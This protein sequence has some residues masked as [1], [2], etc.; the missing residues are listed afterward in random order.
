MTKAIKRRLVGLVIS[1]IIF[2]I[3]LIYFRLRLYEKNPDATSEVLLI[4]IIV[5][6]LGVTCVYSGFDLLLFLWKT[7]LKIGR[8]IALIPAGIKI[9]GIPVGFIFTLILYL[10]TFLLLL[11]GSVYLGLFMPIYALISLIYTYIKEH[12]V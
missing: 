1:S 8:T 12:Q 2:I 5:M 3:M 9:Y 4:C 10:L 11:I 7:G 6:N